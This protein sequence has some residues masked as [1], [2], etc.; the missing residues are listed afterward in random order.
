MS[1]VRAAFNSGKTKDVTFRK[2][3]LKAMKKMLD[4]NESLIEKALI[5][6]LRKPQFETVLA[7]IEVVRNDIRG[8]L[9]DIGHWVKDEPAS[10]VNR[11]HL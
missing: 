6:D 10:K 5:R 1:K 7:E 9:Q 2:T 11:Y 3:Q 8:S 4:E